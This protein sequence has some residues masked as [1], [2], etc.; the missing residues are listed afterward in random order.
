MIGI[1][2]GCSVLLLLLTA[3]LIRMQRRRKEMK[4]YYMAAQRIIQEE[5]LNYAIQ[6]P[7]HA[8]NAQPQMQRMM[9]CLKTEKSK[10]KGFVFDPAKKVH[11]GRSSEGNEICIPDITVSGRHCCLYLSNNELFLADLSS[12][13]GTYVKRGFKKPVFLQGMQLALQTGDRIQVG[14]TVFRVEIFFCDL[15]AA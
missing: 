11:I 4:K 12:S 3:L 1:L 15:L 2:I 9:I 6:N 8:G 5:C 13:N 7:L 14:N 10:Q